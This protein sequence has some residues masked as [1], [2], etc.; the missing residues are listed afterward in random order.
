MAANSS[1]ILK[2]D[3][4]E[5]CVNF[6]NLFVTPDLRDVKIRLHYL[7]FYPKPLWTAETWNEWFDLIRREVELQKHITDNQLWW[8]L[9]HKFSKIYS[10]PMDE[11]YT[12][13]TWDAP[14]TK[15]SPK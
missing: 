3:I 9:F 1:A 5:L 2:S 12:E 8:T 14:D 10:Q 11:A 13:P 4:D 6:K 15:R 7:E